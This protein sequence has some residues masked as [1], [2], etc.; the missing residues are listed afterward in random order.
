M[1]R[2]D[3]LFVAISDHLYNT[4]SLNE[5]DKDDLGLC[6]S[7]IRTG[8]TTL[9]RLVRKYNV[10]EYILEQFLYGD[11]YVLDTLEKLLFDTE[12]F[13]DIEE[14]LIDAIKENPTDYKKF[15]KYILYW[16]RT[17]ELEKE[18]DECVSHISEREGVEAPTFIDTKFNFLEKIVQRELREDE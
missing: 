11:R 10:K 12:E 14:D 17:N 2:L 9:R 6:L 18:F 16:V 1:K 15:A 8:C 3:Q 4:R 5:K 7:Q 13:A